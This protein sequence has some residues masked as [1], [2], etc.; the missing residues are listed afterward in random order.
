MWNEFFFSAPQL[1]RDPLGRFRHISTKT[2]SAFL[3]SSALIGAVA[4]AF[5]AGRMW[6][7]N[8]DA[9]TWLTALATALLTVI[10][11]VQVIRE[12]AHG[13]ETKDAARHKLLPHAWLARRNCLAAADE[14]KQF[15][16][17]EWLLRNVRS[18]DTVEERLVAVASLAAEVGGAEA[19][20][21][22]GALKTFLKAA[23]IVVKGADERLGY[24]T[25]QMTTARDEAGLLYAEVAK[26]LEPITGSVGIA[27]GGRPGI[28]KGGA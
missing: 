5:L 19:S 24:S 2:V 27:V 11:A 12:V 25:E 7:S 9:A 16:C 6:G 3:R 20:A 26:Q 18:L 22:H 14:A 28:A 17:R 13:R 15:G 4:M 23:D 10:A 21:A 1:K 8:S